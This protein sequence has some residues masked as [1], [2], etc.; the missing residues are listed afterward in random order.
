MVDANIPDI[1]HRDVHE[2]ISGEVPIGPTQKRKPLSTF[3]G[4]ANRNVVF[5][6]VLDRIHVLAQYWRS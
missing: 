3:A 1:K 5:H 4:R 6:S 2:Q